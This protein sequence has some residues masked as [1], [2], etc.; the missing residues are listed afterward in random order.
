M[1]SVVALARRASAAA[2]LAFAGTLAAAQSAPPTAPEA[3]SNAAPPSGPASGLAEALEQQ[4]RALALSGGKKAAAGAPRVEVSVGQLDPRLRLAPCQHVEPYVPDGMRMWGKSRVGLRCTQGPTKWNVY[5]PITV[6]VFGTGLVAANGVP[7]GGTLTKN[8]I[9]QAEVDLAEDPS[10]P[11]VNA[12]A[13]VGRTL[14]RA[15][16]AGESLR[17][18]YLKPRQWFA[19][20]ET[21]TMVAQGDGFSV[22]GEAEALNPGIEGQPV[23]VRTDS[24]RVLTGMPSGERRVDLGL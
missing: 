1:N 24:G 5:L 12:D 16:K 17:V 18:S 6:R 20:G 15:V 8:D 10:A 4:V 23:R 19:A 21:V 11:L 3:A 13:V 2:L 22:A 7:S 14:T 9:A